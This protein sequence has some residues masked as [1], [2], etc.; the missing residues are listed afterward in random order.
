MIEDV[1]DIGVEARIMETVEL[2]RSSMIRL[3]A[4]QTMKVQ[5]AGHDF[6]GLEREPQLRLR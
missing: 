5:R 3:T 1:D 6:G 4:P 2:P